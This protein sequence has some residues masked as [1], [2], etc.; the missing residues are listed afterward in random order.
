MCATCSTSSTSVTTTIH[1]LQPIQG[2]G[3]L[4]NP[5]ALSHNGATIGQTYVWNGTQWNLSS[6]SLG[7][8]NFY[9]DDTDALTSGLP[10]GS[11]YILTGDGPYGLPRGTVRYLDSILA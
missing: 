10:V 7:A 8:L 6:P 1:T 11:L 9:D 5:I 3:T 4:L 2:D